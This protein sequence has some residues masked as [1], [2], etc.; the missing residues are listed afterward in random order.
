MK[1]KT[2]S[3]YGL[4]GRH[5]HTVN[6]FE[7]G[8]TYLHAP[9]GYGKSTLV[10]MISL[11]FSGRREELM[12]IPFERMD[13][14]FSDGSNLIAE[15][16]ENGMLIQMQRNELET[17]LTDEDL[18]TLVGVTYIPPERMFVNIDGRMESA[19]ETYAHRLSGKLRDAKDGHAVMVT[20]CEEDMNDDEIVFRSKDLNAKLNFIRDAGFEMDMPSGLRFPPTRYDLMGS[21]KEYTDLLQSITGFVERNYHLSESVIVFKDIM[22]KFLSDKDMAVDD[23]DSIAFLLENGTN[24]PLSSLSSGEKQIFVIFYRLLFETLPS[25]LVIIDEP[26]ISLHVSWQQRI[27]PMIRDIARLRGLQAIIST[28]SPQ[29]IHD[30]WDLTNELR[31]GRA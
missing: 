8:L 14:S 6:V 4:F 24:L 7:E 2:I 18:R 19:V 22:N 5:D 20:A 28:H 21:R 23:N 12:C 16:S 3:V 17:E 1:I 26:E 27:G 9:N 11:L 29:I 10:R 13:I 30:D 25:S 31:A 15:R